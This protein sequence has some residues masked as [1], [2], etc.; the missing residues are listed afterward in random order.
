M[1]PCY[2]VYAIKCTSRVELRHSRRDK[3]RFNAQGGERGSSYESSEAMVLAM[4]D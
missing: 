3:T 2:P 1:D 4:T